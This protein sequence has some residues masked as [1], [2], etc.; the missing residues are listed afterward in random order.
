MT[1]DDVVPIEN[2]NLENDAIRTCAHVQKADKREELDRDVLQ[3]VRNKHAMATT[4]TFEATPFG[5]TMLAM[6][7]SVGDSTKKN[8]SDH[9]RSKD[10]MVA[11]S[12][13]M[14]Y[15]TGTHC[16]KRSVIGNK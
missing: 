4:I 16:S 11:N 7:L 3:S 5:S 8:T 9:S 10:M 12:A 14:K 15:T 2:A 1:G 13:A 6:R